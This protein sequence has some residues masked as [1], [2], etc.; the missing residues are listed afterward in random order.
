MEHSSIACFQKGTHM[1]LNRALGTL[2]AGTA[3]LSIANAALA[4]DGDDVLAKIN[5]V[6]GAQGGKLVAESTEVDGDNVILKNIKM[7]VNGSNEQL[8]LG[9]VTLEGV[10]EGDDAYTIDKVLFQDI[11]MTKDGMTVKASDIS[12]SGVQVA[13]EPK[14]GS[15]NSVLLY[16]TFHAGPISVSEKDKQIFSINAIDANIDVADDESQVDFDGS[17]TGIAVDLTTVPDPK[18]KQTIDALG[19]QNLNGTVTMKGGWTP[20]DGTIDLTEYAFD[21]DD[22]GR[23]DIN[24]SLKGYTLAFVKSLQDT[25]KAAEEN[26]DKAAGQQAMGMAMMGLM[27]QLSYGGA[28]IRFDDAGI[29]QKLLDFAGKQQGVDG[30]QFAQSLKGMLPI[31]LGQLKVPE[32][33]KQISDAASA[34]LDDPKSLTVSAE[35]AQP[36]PFPQ[37]MGAAMA[38][39][40]AQLVNTLNVKVTSND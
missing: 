26:P 13:Y 19:L 40:P 8:P 16:D 2:L 12:L 21:F 35:P 30:Q 36:L 20:A 7:S 23:L 14:P 3:F 11:D 27:A 1:T 34:Y 25:M 17:A 10:E 18:A 22:V 38:G 9:D 29:T 39:D 15:L 33:Q 28:S 37:I 24:L 5:A 32:L 4:L 31:M 6:Y